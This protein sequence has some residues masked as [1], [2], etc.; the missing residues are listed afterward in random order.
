[1]P[2]SRFDIG[3][4]LQEALGLQRQGRLREAEKLYA[5]VLKAAPDNFDALHLLG[6]AKA[7]A[8][9]MGEAQRL[10]AAA[11]KINA[12]SPDAWINF[13][14]VLHALKRDGEA[15]DALDKRAGAAPGRSR[16]AVPSRQ[17]PAR[18]RARGGGA[19]RSSTGSWRRIRARAKRCSAA[20]PRA[21]RSAGLPRRW[22]IS[23]PR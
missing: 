9:Q 22:P 14:N 16:R 6:L 5:R 11:L 4:T 7:Q 3:Q 2:Q 13:A 19:W 10:M 18:A 20:A 1:M 12:Q 23:T 17:R 8:G 15:L 21:Q